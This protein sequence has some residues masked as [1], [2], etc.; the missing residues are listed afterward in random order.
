MF[1]CLG[2]YPV[3]PACTRDGSN[4]TTS[5]IARLLRA[6]ARRREED[7]IRVRHGADSNRMVRRQMTTFKVLAF[8]LR[9][10]RFEPRRFPH[11]ELFLRPSR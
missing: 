4:T 6:P 10:R 2:V 9:A 1:K 5:T 3:E 11:H 8:P 7:S